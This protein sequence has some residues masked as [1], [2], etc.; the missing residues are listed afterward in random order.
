MANLLSGLAEWGGKPHAAIET[1][2]EDYQ[3]RHAA[4]KNFTFYP[5]RSQQRQR[6]PDVLRKYRDQMGGTLP[7]ELQ[8]DAN[9]GQGW[10]RRIPIEYAEIR[11]DGSLCDN[12][13]GLPRTDQGRQTGNTAARIGDAVSPARTLQRFAGRH[14]VERVG[15]GNRQWQG[16]EVRGIQSRIT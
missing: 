4:K 5:L 11:G 14:M 13:N 10:Q 6:Q 15:I 2:K 9:R 3:N 8:G 1:T 12:G 7:L 16:G